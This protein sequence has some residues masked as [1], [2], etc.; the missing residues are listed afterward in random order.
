MSK[1]TADLIVLPQNNGTYILYNVFTHTVLAVDSAALSLLQSENCNSDI[2]K[3]RVWKI[4]RFS[5]E[6]G[7][8]AD[9]SCFQRDTG[10]WGEGEELTAV[11]FL[12]IAKEMS[13]IINDEKEYR[14]RFIAKKGILD[15]HNFGNFHEQLGQ[16]LLTTLRVNP[17][18]WWYNQKFAADKEGIRDNLYKSIQESHLKELFNK[19]FSKQTNIIDL[20]CGIG[21]YTRMM[22]ET[23]AMVI[24]VDPNSDYVEIANRQSEENLTFVEAK[25]G[26]E[27]ISDI[28]DGWAD[29]IFMSDALLF[30]FIPFYPD[31]KAD[32]NILLNDI[33]RL[34]K[35]GGSFISVEPTGAFFLNPWLGEIDNPF[36]VLTEYRDK[37][38]GITPALG[39]LLKVF[40]E[41]DF[42]LKDYQE[43]YPE[44]SGEV[45]DLRAHNFASEFPIWQLLEFTVNKRSAD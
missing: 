26:E 15:F 2:E 4:R 19:R 3:C 34:L 20:G 22:A 41:K 16:H 43:W 9:P 45:Y 44:N 37:K 39:D 29:I 12:A 28:A 36:T 8:L 30:Y 38:H 25:I 21:Y 23:G 35:P 32:L 17:G 7:L 5:N 42:L 40:F 27:N 33:K 10:K 6:D 11:D 1:I 24:G 13:F 31:Q 18:E 14:S